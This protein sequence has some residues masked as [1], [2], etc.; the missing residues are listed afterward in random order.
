[1]L[2]LF[3][4]LI[5]CYNKSVGIKRNVWFAIEQSKALL[6]WLESSARLEQACNQ[7]WLLHIRSKLISI[8][9][10]LKLL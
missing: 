1:M 9:H 5:Y 8:C 3:T 6:P 10:V 4:F 2:D 7:D